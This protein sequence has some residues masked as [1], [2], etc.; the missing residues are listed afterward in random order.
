MSE[1]GGRRASGVSVVI[2]AQDEEANIRAC[3]ESARWADEIVVVDGGSRDR[4]CEIAAAMGARVDHNPW[5]GFSAQRDLAISLATRDW[6]FALDADERVPATLAEE[7]V[8]V[9]QEEAG[10]RNGY[11]VYRDTYFLGRHIRHCGGG[12][13]RVV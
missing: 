7:I 5:P 13:R 4:T 11:L 2:I 6:V 12:E 9:V 3:L 10:E 8:R 1:D